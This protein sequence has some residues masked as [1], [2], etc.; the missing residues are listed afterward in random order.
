MIAVA[1]PAEL[2]DWQLRY[3]DVIYSG[4]TERLGKGNVTDHVTAARLLGSRIAVVVVE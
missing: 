4:Y 2:I 3:L 1:T